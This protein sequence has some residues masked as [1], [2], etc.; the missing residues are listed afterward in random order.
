M[1][2]LLAL[3]VLIAVGFLQAA[4]LSDFSLSTYGPESVVPGHYMFFVVSGTVVT[5]ENDQ[6]VTP[7]IA[8]LPAGV[9]AEFINLTRFCCGTKLWRVDSATPVKISASV[10]ATPGT[11]PLTITY[12]TDNAVSKSTEY[13]LTVLDQPTPLVLGEFAEVTATPNL[14]KWESNMVTYGKSHC[15]PE[16]MS[17]WE[18]FAWYYDGQRVYFQIADYTKDLSWNT[19]AAMEEG[20]YRPFVISNNGAIQGWRVF[21]HGLAMD[22][23][24]FGDSASRDAAVMLYTGGY[25]KNQQLIGHINWDASREVAYAL[26]AAVVRE[27]LGFPREAELQDMAEI[28]L[29]HFDQWFVSEK[30]TY[31][32]P[33]MVAL[34]AEALI[35]YYE[36]TEDD[37][38]P[39]L[40]KLAADQLWANSWDGTSASFL[41]ENGDTTTSVAPDINLLIVPLYGWVYRQTADLD[42]RTNGD[43][44]FT[45]GVDG[46]WLAGGKQ[47]SENYRWS[48]DYLRWRNAGVAPTPAHTIRGRVKI[49]VVGTP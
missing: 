25:A 20:V 27:R 31:T 38:V 41:Y 4:P 1:K 8:G 30:A 26:N 9:T 3:L 42:Y 39:P 35:G 5:G 37:R 16:E 23:E 2:R 36:L 29:G 18:G 6:M 13:S 49:N 11:Y 7:S 40:L 19:C 43:A 28:V 10:S 14:A 47:F 32:Q 46:A 17:L 45:A 48:F 24:R 33:F 21:P 22:V 34:S 15:V 12:L 44:A